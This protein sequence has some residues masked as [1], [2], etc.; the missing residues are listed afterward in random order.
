MINFA[1]KTLK[2]LN[3]P[4]F[5]IKKTN[6]EIVFVN[7]NMTNT[8]HTD[9]SGIE[10]FFLK[11]FEFSLLEQQ[12]YISFG[13]LLRFGD[14]SLESRFTLG[15]VDLVSNKRYIF[16]TFV[17][18]LDDSDER[19]VIIQLCDISKR[20][21]DS[22]IGAFASHKTLHKN[23]DFLVVTELMRNIAHHW[24]QPL[25]VFMMIL[26]II[27]DS[28][29]GCDHCGKLEYEK[30]ISFIDLLRETSARINTDINA[31]RFAYMEEKGQQ[32]IARS[33]EVCV[34]IFENK[35]LAKIVVE[36]T[37]KGN[38]SF[39]GNGFGIRTVIFTLLNNAY[40]SLQRK[41]ESK[42]CFTPYIRIRLSES[43]NK[44]YVYVEDNGEGFVDVDPE[45]IFEPYYS[46]KYPKSMTGLSLF[47]AK[48]ILNEF[49]GE[50]RVLKSK[51][52]ATFRIALPKKR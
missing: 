46:S 25:S 13:E 17:S 45:K 33:I 31:I 18:A 26:D 20:Y 7:E 34:K 8:F 22:G 21:I 51:E 19:Y 42:A 30:V 15:A 39:C 35:N 2:I 47:N 14:Y 52:G 27:K 37:T 16:D 49:G 5:I 11:R 44:I 4:S 3:I 28:L 12:Q 32:D 24:R 50:I 36:N 48:A 41:T 1:I 10:E 23:T 6:Q 40:E 9:Q 38:L 43:A 29:E